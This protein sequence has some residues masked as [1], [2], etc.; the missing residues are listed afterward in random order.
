M[1]IVQN[2]D[3]VQYSNQ[4][5]NTIYQVLEGALRYECSNQAQA[6]DILPKR[7]S[8]RR[9]IPQFSSKRL[10][11]HGQVIWRHRHMEGKQNK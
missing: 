6:K 3:Y 2:G 5:L 7:Q 8:L 9:D 11:S 1:F 10:L 4:T